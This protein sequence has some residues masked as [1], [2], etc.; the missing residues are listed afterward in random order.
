VLRFGL[1]LLVTALAV[2]LFAYLFGSLIEVNAFTSAL[3]FALLV[4]LLNAFLRPVI[5]L[6]TL[7]LTIITLG[8]FTLVVNA[9]IFWLASL[10]PVGVAVRG[11]A[12]AFLAALAV[13]VVS[14]VASRMLE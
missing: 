8:L 5:L 12:G 3:L 11:F 9:L 7:P 4:G 13:S 2:L 6:L 1:R 14:F 10:F